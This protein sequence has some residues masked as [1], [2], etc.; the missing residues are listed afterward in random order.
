HGYLMT[1][2]TPVFAQPTQLK[3][4]QHYCDYVYVDPQRSDQNIHLR[5]TQGQPLSRALTQPQLNGAP[6]ALSKLREVLRNMSTLVNHTI[7]E[8]R[9]NGQ[10]ELKPIYSELDT[11]LDS[12]LENT[13]GMQW[14]IATEPVKG[15]LSRRA[16]GTSMLCIVFGRQLGLERH[17]LLQLALGGLLLDIG[18]V[19]VP[20]TILAK[21]ERLNAEEKWFT[22]RHVQQSLA[23]MHFNGENL[24]RV[25][26]M[27][28][29]HHERLDGSGYP[30]QITGTN[31]PLYARIAGIVDTFDALTLN[32]RYAPA[33]SGYSAL[34]FL[35]ALRQTKFDAALVDEFIL[36]LGI[37]P[38][39]TRVQL[40]D[41]STGLVLGQ[42]SGQPRQ[43]NVLLTHDTAGQPVKTIRIVTIGLTTPITQT[44][45]TAGQ[46]E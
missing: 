23:M 8:A 41:G 15:F 40:D 29:A 14:L 21:P 22:T 20:I 28:A 45:P 26:P 36:S 43:P 12:T 2:P 6:H 10:I 35:S 42:N 37:Y 33:R 46:K 39:G 5:L 25:V 3:A 1:K 13:D 27:I 7:R 11:F 4:L 9:Q 44:F 16:L 38:I 34:R 30:N 17:E 24:D 31:I 19:S 32:R 18:K